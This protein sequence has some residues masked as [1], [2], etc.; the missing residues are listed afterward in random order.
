MSLTSNESSVLFRIHVANRR[1]N[2]VACLSAT[3]DIGK[4]PAHQVF[5]VLAR[6]LSELGAML[7][8]NTTA[9]LPILDRLI[10]HAH[11]ARH[12]GERVKMRNRAVK[13]WVHISCEVGVF[14][15]S[16]AQIWLVTQAKLQ[17]PQGLPAAIFHP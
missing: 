15:F 9:G 12:V 7:R 4:I 11:L 1:L 16:L 13:G 5:A 17:L 3:D 10:R 6:Q 2:V 8:W 14:E